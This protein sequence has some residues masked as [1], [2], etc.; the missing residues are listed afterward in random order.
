M[1]TH[2]AAAPAT[3]EPAGQTGEWTDLT[4]TDM[5]PWAEKAATPGWTVDHDRDRDR[6]GLAACREALRLLH[7]ETAYVTPTPE[8]LADARRQARAVLARMD[9]DRG[10]KILA[11]ILFPEMVARLDADR[12][13][14]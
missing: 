6:A 5:D 14:P 10:N 3:Q 13:T 11:Q 2:S 9:A 12:G 8:P 7:D 1:T 4:G